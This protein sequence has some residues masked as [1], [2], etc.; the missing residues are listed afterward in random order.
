MV[1]KSSCLRKLIPI[2]LLPAASIIPVNAEGTAAT[3]STDEVSVSADYYKS[4]TFEWTDSEGKSHVSDLT[5]PATEFNHILALIKEVYLNPA[6]PGYTHDI[7]AEMLG[8]Q[9]RIDIA[10]VPY[11]W[12]TFG[13][14]RQQRRTQLRDRP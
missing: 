4:F 11:L 5:E 2:L 9:E 6:I 8:D 13:K 10:E 3:D 14:Q 7:S 1:I 12:G